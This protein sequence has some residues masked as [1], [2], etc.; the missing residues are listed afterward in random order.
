MRACGCGGRASGCRGEGVV[1]AAGGG[2]RGGFEV[3]GACI[4]GDRGAVGEVDRW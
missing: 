2:G 4:G 3:D 1:A